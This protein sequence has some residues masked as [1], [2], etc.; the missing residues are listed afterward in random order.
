MT[1]TAFLPSFAIL[2]ALAAC[3]GGE[4]APA[5]EAAPQAQAPAADSGAGAPIGPISSREGSSPSAPMAPMGG[6]PADAPSGNINFELPDGWVSQPPANKMRV[7]QAEIPGSG[8]PGQLVVFYFGPGGG[9]TVEANIERWMGQVE[10]SAGAHPQPQAF[11]T[12]TGY[13]VTWIDVPGTLKPSTMGMGPDTEQPNS[14]LLGGIV[15]GPG[16]PWFFKATGPDA[17]MTAERDAFINML[18]SVRARLA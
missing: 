9:G 2:L 10:V 5:P 6:A 7:A 4:E 14:R 15:E 11:E 12:G 16:G 3:G 8:G 13:K 18:K 1:R 17:T